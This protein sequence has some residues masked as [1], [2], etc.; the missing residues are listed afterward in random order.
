MATAI[1]FRH[2]YSDRSLAEFWTF[3]TGTHPKNSSESFPYR[4]AQRGPEL[5]RLVAEYVLTPP[6]LLYVGTDA[7]HIFASKVAGDANAMSQ[8]RVL[9]SPSPLLSCTSKPWSSLV[10]PQRVSALVANRLWLVAAFANGTLRIFDQPSGCERAPLSLDVCLPT[11]TMVITGSTLFLASRRAL[12][13]VDLAKISLVLQLRLPFTARP[14]VIVEDST[15]FVKC[16]ELVRLWPTASKLEVQEGSLKAR[17]P[18]DLK[19]LHSQ[20]LVD[21]CVCRGVESD[22]IITASPVEIQARLWRRNLEHGGTEPLWKLCRK[23]LFPEQ[24]LMSV[25]SLFLV[26]QRTGAPQLVVHG[27]H[28]DRAAVRVLSC[29][30]D[31]THNTQEV[32]FSQA[33]QGSWCAARVGGGSAGCGHSLIT[34]L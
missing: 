18:I 21:M 6:S 5:L 31:T 16:D 33:A 11:Q 1:S 17:K 30:S 32:F 12:L 22:T 3:L 2:R 15:V 29:K 7:G 28:E 20:M 9:V 19:A 10:S 23:S 24:S 14:K 27:K 26:Q 8:L 4:L 25:D 34:N 13:I